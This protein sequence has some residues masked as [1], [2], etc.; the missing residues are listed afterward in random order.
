MRSDSRQP[1]EAG[2][3]RRGVAGR[4]RA[5]LPVALGVA[6]GL[7]LCGLVYLALTFFNQPAPDPAPTARAIC[8]DLTTQRYDGLYTLLSP[9][10]Q[11]QGSAGQFSASQRE[12]D[13]LIG[14]ARTCA[15]SVSSVSGATADISLTLQR[16]KASE[17]Q[18]TL[19][20]VSGAWRIAS[21]EQT[22]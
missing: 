22:V 18:V 7:A 5:W 11:A 16:T 2:S 1:V 6:A 9:D 3:T 4:P 14:P 8:A 17:A 19:I 13:Q 15:A 10:L 20:Q 21:Y 12:L